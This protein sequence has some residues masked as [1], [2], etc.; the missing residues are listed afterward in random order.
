[1]IT[2]DPRLFNIHVRVLLEKEADEHA[3]LDAE[4][5][6]ISQRLRALVDEPSTH[7]DV[8]EHELYP[9]LGAEI[10]SERGKR[11]NADWPG[12]ERVQEWDQRIKKMP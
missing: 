12:E 8:T 9:G 3:R 7:Y 1:M 6:E 2:V 4:K 10:L 5:K 11:V